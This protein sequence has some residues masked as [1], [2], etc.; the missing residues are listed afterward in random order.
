MHTTTRCMMFKASLYGVVLILFSS[1]ETGAFFIPICRNAYDSRHFHAKFSTPT[2]LGAT[3]N[4]N[5]NEA[6]QLDNSKD[7][8]VWTKAS[9][10]AV[11]TFGKFFGTANSASFAVVSTDRTPTSVAETKKRIQ[12]DNE[13]YVIVSS[14]ST[15]I[16]S[17]SS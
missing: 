3:S 17:L 4:K 13:R 5:N 16:V 10:Y 15:S 1:M 14:I 2:T 8:D 6:S 9:W 11:E 7:V 12:R